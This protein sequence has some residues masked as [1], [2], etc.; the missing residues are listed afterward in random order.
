MIWP[1]ADPHD[2]VTSQLALSVFLPFATDVQAGRF[3]LGDGKGE[4]V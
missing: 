2:W 1:G 3:L 4:G